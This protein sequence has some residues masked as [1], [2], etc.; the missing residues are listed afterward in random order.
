MKRGMNN[1]PRPIQPF[2][3]RCRLAFAFGLM[4]LV[5][6]CLRDV[7]ANESLSRTDI[8][9]GLLPRNIQL[10]ILS[11]YD[12]L[13]QAAVNSIVQD[14]HG[15]MW[16]GT[17]EG[18]NRYDGYKIEVYQH[19]HNDPRSLAHDWI[20]TTYVDQS[21]QLWVGTDGGGLSQYV[22]ESDDFINIK[23]DPS[24]P[25]SLSSNRI[26]VIFQ[27]NEGV[28]W[29]GTDGGGL[30]RM[31][32]GDGGFIHYRHD[33]QDP[34]SL[35]GD[36]VEAIIEDR[37]G[38][39]WIATNSG[40]ARFDRR[41]QIF[42]RYQHDPAKPDSLVDNRV[43]ALLEDTDGGLWIGTQHGLSHFNV[44]TGNFTRFQH[45]PQDPY[46]LNHDEVR[47]IHQDQDGTLWIATDAGLNEWRRDQRSFIRYSHDPLNRTSLPNNRVT[48]LYQ[49]S[50]GVLWIGTY[51]GIG[52]WNFISDTFM[53]YQQISDSQS[54]LSN[55]LVTG[56]SASRESIWIGTYGGGL[57]RLDIASGKIEHF[58]RD[59]AN[60]NSLSDDRVMAVLVDKA[61]QVWTGT[62]NHG[63][64]RFD[65]ETETFTHFKKDPDNENSI[66]ADGVT[67]I[68]A[69]D[70]TLWIGTYGGGLN[71]LDLNTGF[72]THYQHDADDNLSISSDRVLAIY[73]DSS[74]T[75]WIGT[76]DGGLNQFDE[77][78]QTFIRYQH[79]PEQAA[80]LGSNTAWE[81]LEGQDGSL[82]IATR[83]G[84]LNR[85][86]AADR[87]AG[88]RVF[89]KYLKQD[90]LIS[91]T[92]HGILEDNS[93]ALWLSSNRGLTRFD[94][95]NNTIRHFDESNGL[96]GKEFTFGARFK[97]TDGTLMFGGT[98][99]L[100]VFDPS[101]L[102]I[103]QHK[104]QVAVTALLQMSPVMKSFSTNPMPAKLNLNY[105]DYA[106]SFE[107]T[108]L[109][110]T[111]SDKNRYKYILEG[112]EKDWI[113]SNDYRRATY[114]NLAPG[115]YTFKVMG[116]NSD[117]LWSEDVAAID[118]HV[119]PP[120]WRTG[121]AYALYTLLILSILMLI[122]RGQ[123]NRLKRA[124]VQRRELEV[125]VDRR[126]RE[127]QEQN[128][129][130]EELSK[131]LEKASYTDQLTG[132]NNRRYLHQIMESEMATLDRYPEEKPTDGGKPVALDIS[133]GLAIIMIDLDGF[134][135]INDEHGHHA[136]DL[137]LI[138]VRDILQKCCRKS[139]TIIRWGGDEFVIVG[140]HSSRLGAEKYAERIRFELAN[141]QYQIGGGNVA[142]LSGSIGV[143]MYPFIPNNISMLTWEQVITIAD[144]AAYLA[145]ENGRNAWVGLYGSRRV[146]PDD[147]FERMR[148]DPENLIKQGL[149]KV[150]TSLE[151]A[152]DFSNNKIRSKLS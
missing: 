66:S 122:L 107:F 38:M 124:E 22:Y 61:G 105:R 29:I 52:K 136:G 91:N 15:F 113:Q 106:I 39:L 46:S 94:P 25:S 7:L 127:L 64:S 87:Q 82:W 24:D 104:P 142:R 119:L 28:R 110:Y 32:A 114:T 97:H 143:T 9:S 112:F 125:Q 133:A 12:G 141:H 115:H 31:N 79:D 21:G 152:L 140:R 68:Y 20:W 17:Q 36:K 148:N 76:E 44:A 33:P 3:Q 75:L 5:L 100:V 62:R 56:I 10:S 50:G 14:K 65:P 144:Q 74:G 139:D 42:H 102:H 83:D 109:D 45:D 23:H 108:A 81:I 40:L 69:D 8:G 145:K 4:I 120:P 37:N 73:R 30:N 93:G 53:H 67:S 117:A 118:I 26:R 123:M 126:T 55:N 149:V 13:S 16:F 147:I 111:S 150:T 128:K 59:P 85:W 2:A 71:K 11:T 134:K 27:D 92:L 34:S 18:L 138:Q 146:T 78:N 135:Q 54:S 90:G 57:N 101:M 129:E 88:R 121:W 6:V 137:A 1:L 103:N 58:Q 70:E 48:S 151:T 116:T 43:R 132:L 84:G 98:D 96:P 86:S 19:D 130:L 89:S 35:P 80:S 99:G 47:T 51:N 60:S 72:F 49:D 77:S 63:L 95:G 41:N 131:Q